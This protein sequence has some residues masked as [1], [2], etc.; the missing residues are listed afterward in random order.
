MPHTEVVNTNFSRGRDL[1]SRCEVA[2]KRMVKEE[3]V[4]VVLF[5]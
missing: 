3:R 5:P 1:L 4:G 2:E